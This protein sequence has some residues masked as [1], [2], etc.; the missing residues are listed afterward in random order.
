MRTVCACEIHIDTGTVLLPLSESA[1][2]DLS[3]TA[4]SHARSSNQFL[5]LS[6]SPQVVR[7]A[8]S[9]VIILPAVSVCTER[10][11]QFFYTALRT[12]FVEIVDSHK[13]NQHTFFKVQ[14]SRPTDPL[15][16]SADSFIDSES[17][18]L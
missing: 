18:P 4:L 5:L 14:N 12:Y 1:H 7:N 10:F 13:G 11:K 15:H 2:F 16:S 3:L 9:G 8:S 6:C 17:I